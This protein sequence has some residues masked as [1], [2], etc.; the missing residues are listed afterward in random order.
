MEELA[1]PAAEKEREAAEKEKDP[2]GFTCNFC[3]VQ[4]TDAR[5]SGGA[6]KKNW[7]FC[8]STCRDK[9]KSAPQKRK[10]CEHRHRKGQ[11]SDCGTGCCKHRR[12]KYR[13]GIAG[14]SNCKHGPRIFAKV[15]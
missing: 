4:Y 2:K 13:R 15:A 12:R 5:G 7:G 8:S 10:E 14:R 3:S 1:Q 9:N 6:T 11:C